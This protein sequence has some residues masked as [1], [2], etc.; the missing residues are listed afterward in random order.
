MAGSAESTGAAVD[1]L[2]VAAAGLDAG[3]AWLE[4]HLGVPLAPGG[5]H[6]AMERAK[7]QREASQPKNTEALK[8]S[9]QKEIDEIEARRQAAHLTEAAPPV[10]T[11]EKTE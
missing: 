3:T 2:V 9:Q 6:A 11:G 7:A 4:A 10:A 8:S 5:R 1:H